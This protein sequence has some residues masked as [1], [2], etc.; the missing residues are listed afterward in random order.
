[1]PEF[2]TALPWLIGLLVA[3][4]IALAGL[5]AATAGYFV[6]AAIVAQ[7]LHGILLTVAPER[8]RPLAI[9]IA[10]SGAAILFGA[11]IVVI[12]AIRAF[13]RTRL[14]AA[15]AASA[16]QLR[17]F[18]DRAPAAI[19]MFDTN[20]HYLAASRRY[21]EDYHLDSV[22]GP[23][24]VVGQS[25]YDLFPRIPECRRDIHRRVLAGEMLSAEDDPFLRTDGG[26][27][28]L[29]WEM[30]PWRLAD[31]EI[32]GAMLLSEVV[33]ARRQAASG[34][35]FLLDFVDRLRATPLET[36]AVT[37]VLLGEHFGVSRVCFG[38]VDDGGEFVAV[39]HQY[40]DATVAPT[41]GPPGLASFGL[42]I[43]EQLRSGR[44]LVVED[45]IE[46]PRTCTMR[47]ACAIAGARS[48]VV[49]PLLRDG[50]L[51]AL[52]YLNHVKP[53][54]WTVYETQ[55]LDQVAAR[56]WAAVEHARLQGLVEQ[57]AE[58]FHT[59]ADGVPSLCWMANPDGHIHW[60]NRRWYEYTGSTFEDMQAQG[61]PVHDP[62]VVPGVMDYWRASIASGAPFE[63]TFPLRG[64]DGVLRHFMT[65]I[66]PVFDA[67]GHVKRWLG[68]SVDVS[69]AMER[70]TALRH[71]E[72]ALRKSEERF[73]Q[74]VEYAPNA[75]VVVGAAG[76]IQIVNAQL[77]QMF[78]HQRSDLIGQPIEMLLPARY[79][80][81]HPVFV[82]SLF[83]DLS[84]RPMGAGRDIYAL[85]K[86]GSEF[87][88]EIGLNPIE[89][90]DGV[91]VLSAVTDLSERKEKEARVM[92]A[93]QEK[94]ILLRE[95]H[96]R[97]K[98]NL[99][100]VHSL[101]DL[102]SRHVSD[103]ATREMLRVSQSRVRSMALIH[104]TLY[105]SNDFA[106]IDFSEFLGS[107][108][109]I[110]VESYGIDLSRVSVC[111]DAD[112]VRLPIDVAVPCGLVVNELIT[113]AFRHAIADRDRA[114]IRVALTT[115]ASNEAVLTVSDDGIGIPDH[116]DIAST[117]TL[118]LQ[119][120][121]L[122]ADQ[123]GGS[124]TLRRSN[125]TQLMLRFPI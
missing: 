24:A 39:R 87:P 60:Y 23:S 51:R 44:T 115:L 36:I 66:A 31:G 17:L 26:V 56:T 15:L 27:D 22:A 122:L 47:S 78:G 70:E 75:M 88:V 76:I 101:L 92:E 50:Q 61:W 35:A 20:M 12:L 57:T 58:E 89:T 112:P 48:I 121:H 53:R 73:R 45:V 117:R 11:I 90:D 21:F 65:R 42:E 13:I 25:Y 106:K 54:A 9:A 71:S 16:S 8:P 100:I 72:A 95:I 10:A 125:P 14:A 64:A 104:Q 41:A 120:V 77:E 82:Q 111:V 80:H 103:P 1:M 49:L 30:M 59:L 102:Q 108:I 110:L 6:H 74:V 19:A 68:A 97:V 84:A 5:M 86:D 7:A 99:Q 29:R 4:S 83:A 28:W 96:H 123:L 46:D 62:D 81:E 33:T 37:P 107:L 93:L 119:L 105:A 43:I 2:G 63:M 18:V 116:I 34:Q 38:E 55:L 67:D 124:I 109:P 114:E 52:L 32:G 40:T 3:L 118:G 94:D 91:V 85:R 69:D 98:N 79:R 113:N